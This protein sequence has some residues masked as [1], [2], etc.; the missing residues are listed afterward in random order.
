[1]AADAV[2]DEEVAEEVTGGEMSSAITIL[3][4]NQTVLTQL[5]ADKDA[6]LAGSSSGS[7][8]ASLRGPGLLLRRRRQFFQDPGKQWDNLNV[9]AG[10]LMHSEDAS[11]WSMERYG[12]EVVTWGQNRLAKR[13]FML[14]AK[15]HRSMK[16]GNEALTRGYLA[17][18]L[19]FLERTA[20][21]HGSQELAVTL[22]PYEDVWTGSERNPAPIHLQDPFEGLSD[23]EEAALALRFISDMSTFNKA[24]QERLKGKGKGKEEKEKDNKGK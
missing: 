24:K 2:E 6:G 1:M 10:E 15:M 11:G 21:D 19:K 14:L 8:P 16:A 9:R 3:V 7:D 20:R 4:K 12:R 23:G 17:Q 18:G 5:L 22:L 13:M